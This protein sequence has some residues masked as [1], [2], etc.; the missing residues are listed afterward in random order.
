MI[1]DAFFMR[2]NEGINRFVGQVVIENGSQSFDNQNKQ[3][4]GTM[5]E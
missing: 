3:S 4:G 1:F 5:Y 2:V